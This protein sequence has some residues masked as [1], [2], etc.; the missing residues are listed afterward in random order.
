MAEV[1]AVGSI[2]IPMPQFVEGVLG[3]LAYRAMR[4]HVQASS[5]RQSARPARPNSRRHDPELERI[6]L[7]RHSI[8]AM[9]GASAVFP[10]AGTELLLPPRLRTGAFAEAMALS[11]GRAEVHGPARRSSSGARWCSRCC[12]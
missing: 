3:L 11:P 9:A 7:D 1:L 4:V 2:P 8:G 5:V 12:R 10:G 6:Y